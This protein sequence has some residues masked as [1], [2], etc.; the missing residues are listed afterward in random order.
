[1]Q[2]FEDIDDV[3]A[4]LEPMDYTRFW[5]AVDP[6]SLDLEPKWHLDGMIAL[7]EVTE[8][9]VLSVLKSM[10]RFQL[11]QMLGLKW[12][13]YWPANIDTWWTEH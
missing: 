7:G 4:W 2:D 11:S 6:Y 1:M 3:V 9:T 12:R 10:A 13:I 5:D 8:A